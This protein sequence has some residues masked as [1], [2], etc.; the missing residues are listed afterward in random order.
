[1]PETFWGWIGL[2]I[3]CVAVIGL[4]VEGVRLLTGRNKKRSRSSF[5]VAESGLGLLVL[6]IAIMALFSRKK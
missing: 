6:L 2:T 3:L 5:G 4:I 1:M